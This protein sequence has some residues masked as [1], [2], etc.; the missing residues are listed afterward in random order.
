MCSWVACLVMCIE[1]FCMGSV[2]FLREDV[3]VV[4][5]LFEELFP[6]KSHRLSGA[7]YD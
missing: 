6:E 7:T 2:Q 3:V 1:L 4:S 5:Y